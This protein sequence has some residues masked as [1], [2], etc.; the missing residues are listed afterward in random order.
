MASYTHKA[1]FL[2]E[3]GR[4][5]ST[6]INAKKEMRMV[7]FHIIQRLRNG[8]CPIGTDFPFVSDCGYV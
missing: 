2:T 8:Q 6:K 3:T 5:A 7:V 4:K 1:G